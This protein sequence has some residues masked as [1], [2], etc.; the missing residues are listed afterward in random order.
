MYNYQLQSSEVVCLECPKG[1]QGNLCELCDDG[2]YNP[3]S[4]LLVTSSSSCQKCH[5]NGNIDENAIGNCDT[6]SSV[7]YCFRCIFNTTG[8]NCEQCLSNYWGNALTSKKCHSCD[9]F[10][11]GTFAD[12]ETGQV[13]QCDLETGQCECKKNVKGRN[14]NECK[15]GYWNI[16]SGEGCE[17]CKCNPL[18]SYNQ[19]CDS[20]TGQCFCRPGVQGKI[21]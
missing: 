12:E 2:H 3:T 13:R 15:N 10:A 19:T 11:L 21:I 16:L 14:C 7:E 17:E 6:T 8:S 5:C 20:K 4:S 1:T 9:C 18:G